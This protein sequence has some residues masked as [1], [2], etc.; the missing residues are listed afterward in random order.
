MNVPVSSYSPPPPAKKSNRGLVVGLIVAVVL[1]CCCCLVAAAVIVVLDPFQLDIAPSLEIAIGSLFGRGD[2]AAQAMPTQTSLYMGVN[3][4]NATPDKLDRVLQPLLQAAGESTIQNTDEAIAEMDKNLLSELGITFKDDIQPWI[5]QYA[6]LGIS[7]VQMSSYGS[8]QSAKFVFAIEARDTA[9]ADAFL[10]KFKDAMAAKNNMTFTETDYQGARIYAYTPE[11]G[12]GAAFTRSGNVVLLAL[13]AE[14]LQGAIDAQKGESIGDNK[15]FQQLAKE[16]PSNSVMTMY[17][18]MAQFTDLYLALMESSSAM[19][20]NPL[21]SMDTEQFR[22]AIQQAYG[23]LSGVG[24]SLS[25]VDAGLQLDSVVAYNMDKLSAEEK[26]N[27][28]TEVKT[29][30]A[31]SMLPDNTLL[32][33]GLSGGGNVDW[34]KIRDQLLQVYGISEEEY[35]QSMTQA[36]Q[37]LG[38]NPDTDL[39]PYLGHDIAL[40]II[41]S[42]QG[43]VAMQAQMNLG[44]AMFVEVTDSNAVLNS[45]DS[46]T[47]AM[48][49]QGLT[50]TRN[51]SNGLVYYDAASSGINMFALGV[52]KDYLVA[53]TSSQMLTDLYAGGSSLANSQRYQQAT[54]ALPKGMTP[55]VYLDLE[56]LVGTVREGMSG[57]QLESFN[58]SMKVLEAMPTFVMGASS[59]KNGVAHASMVLFVRPP[60]K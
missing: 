4:L 22:S 37:A 6:G 38:F 14:D 16:L 3:L 46:F 15:A 26:A 59:T 60:A 13:S 28:N 5:G 33:Y 24:I 51:E 58:E 10:V 30:R 9:K 25:V 20:A 49:A 45:V 36:E 34:N 43:L 56:G 41:P 50:F 48:Q 44:G 40:G 19:G 23:K 35:Q 29:S 31:L 53:G 7:E 12:E 2:T 54:S 17:L 52:G 42:T 55:M 21:G 57:Y 11:A 1:L 47:N 39:F 8:L 32:Y 18:D 27:L